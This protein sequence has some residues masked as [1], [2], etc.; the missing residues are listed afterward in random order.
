AVG[1]AGTR[2]LERFGG[3]RSA[4]TAVAAGEVLGAL[5]L[6]PGLTALFHGLGSDL[7]KRAFSFR[8]PAGRC[9]LCHGSGRERVALEV[10]ADLDLPCS[11]CEGARYRP[12]VLALRWE[13][14]SIQDVLDLSADALASHLPAGKLREGLTALSR[15]GLGHLS[16]GR[17]TRELSGGELQR[18][19]LVSSGLGAQG[20][21]K[22]TLYLLEEPATGLHEADLARLGVLLTELGA[23][24]DLVV[25]TVHRLSLIRVADEV[26]DLGPGAGAAGGRVVAQGAPDSLREGATASALRA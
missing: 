21:S 9:E 25:A 26:I 16:L 1:C 5:G 18:L 10:L 17:R 13:G 23:R 12:A 14:L 2:G 7:P 3:V 22:P 24:G 6:L 20:S 4:Q 19:T 15:V 8:S 11:A